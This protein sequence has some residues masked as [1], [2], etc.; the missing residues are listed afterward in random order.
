MSTV[1]RLNLSS[2]EINDRNPSMTMGA[3][4]KALPYTIFQEGQNPFPSLRN[5]FKL[6]NKTVFWHHNQQPFQ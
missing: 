5:Y 3:D 1:D 2:H 6:P 4:I